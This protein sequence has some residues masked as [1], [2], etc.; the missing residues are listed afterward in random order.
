[1]VIDQQ[2]LQFIEKQFEPVELF[3]PLELFF[4]L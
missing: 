1:M 4:P 3:E 2:I